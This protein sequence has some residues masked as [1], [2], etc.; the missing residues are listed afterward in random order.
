[1]RDLEWL[2][3]SWTAPSGSGPPSFAETLV[4]QF[5]PRERFIGSWRFAGPTRLYPFAFACVLRVAYMAKRDSDPLLSSSSPSTSSAGGTVRHG[6][7]RNS[8]PRVGGTGE[9]LM[10]CKGGVKKTEI[11]TSTVFQGRAV[12]PTTYITWSGSFSNLD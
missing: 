1:M 7:E 4:L 3:S 5:I 10:M 12:W 8:F 2:P 9:G 11:Q 6:K